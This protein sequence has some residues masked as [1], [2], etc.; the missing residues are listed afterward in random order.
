MNRAEREKKE[1]DDRDRYD[2]DLDALCP[3]RA[4]C[5][6]IFFFDEEEEARAMLLA[7]KERLV[8]TAI[9]FSVHWS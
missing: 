8:S 5:S 4:K 2:S 3:V 1:C 7:R 9:S 6:R